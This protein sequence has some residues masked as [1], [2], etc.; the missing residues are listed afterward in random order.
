MNIS[1]DM[2]VRTSV[3]LVDS[4]LDYFYPPKDIFE[5]QEGFT[6]YMGK[7]SGLVHEFTDTDVMNGRTYYYAIVAYDN[8]DFNKGIM[9]SQNSWNITTDEGS[10]K[11]QSTSSNVAVVIPRVKSLGYVAPSGSLLKNIITTGT[12]KIQYNIVD[13]N[14]VTGNTYVVTFKDT[15]DSGKMVPSTTTYTVLDSLFYSETVVPGKVDTLF[16][17]T[18]RKNFVP[19]SVTMTGIDGTVI[20]S[21]KYLINY[22]RG[23]LR[24]KNPQDLQP[25]PANLK[26][27]TIQYR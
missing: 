6:Y 23:A 20:P 13:E 10:G 3:D 11:I 4:V 1:V 24:A 19:G 12:G 9:P 26:K 18:Q 2:R 14:K 15:R 5:G 8:G 21:S 17:F 7:N 27:Y 16:I 22:E 25:D